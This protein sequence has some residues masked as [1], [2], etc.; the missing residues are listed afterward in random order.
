MSESISALLLGAFAFLGWA[1][2]FRR[3]EKPPAP[4]YLPQQRLVYCEFTVTA[5][6]GIPNQFSAEGW[7]NESAYTVYLPHAVIM[8][9]GTVQRPGKDYQVNGGKLYFAANLTPGD[10]IGVFGLKVMP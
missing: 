6:T 5:S 4:V 3:L 10:V 7:G 8:L 1:L 2:F 9:N